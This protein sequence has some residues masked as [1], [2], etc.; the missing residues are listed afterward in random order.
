MGDWENWL[1]EPVVWKYTG[2]IPRRVAIKEFVY[3]G[4]IPFIESYKY[5]FS[6]QPNELTSRI[7]SGLFTRN[8]FY[9]EWTHCLRKE[10]FDEVPHKEFYEKLIDIDAW[11]EFWKRWGVW[12]DVSADSSWGRERQM[13]IESYIWSQL[14]LKHSIHTRTVNELLGIF[15]EDVSEHDSKDTYF[16]DT[17][18]TSWI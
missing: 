5:V 12:S 3:D 18:K 11:E 17:T 1:N 6:A 15:D 9:D 4:L 10:E 8:E 7:A 2:Q 14:S 16:E 13:E